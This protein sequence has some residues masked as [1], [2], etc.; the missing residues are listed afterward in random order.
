MLA[1]MIPLFTAPVLGYDSSIATYTWVPTDPNY[2]LDAIIHPGTIDLSSL[3]MGDFLGISHDQPNAIGYGDSGDIVNWDDTGVDNIG[4]PNSNG[5]ALDG[6]WVKMTR[7]KL[8]RGYWDMGFQTDIV[9]VFQSQDHDHGPYLAEGVGASVHGVNHPWGMLTAK[10]AILTDIYLDGWRI[11]N[12]REDGNGNGWCSDDIVGVY[13]FPNK[14]RYVCIVPWVGKGYNPE[15]VEVDAVAAPGSEISVNF[16]IKPG[17]CPNP[18]NRKSKGVLPV[19]I[20]GTED[21]D[22]TTIDPGTI[23]L[24]REGVDVY[25]SPLCW[26]LE[27]V[28]TPFEGELCDCHELGGDGFTD[29]TIKFKIQEVKELLSDADLDLEITLTIIGNLKEEYGGSP[30][31]GQDCVWVIK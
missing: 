6:L 28:A 26:S 27:D 10:P 22:V 11:H 9:V 30:I 14:Y 29:L 13:K 20:C 8:Y 1:A 3:V 17:S 24:T 21:F 31:S 7:E 5:D 18:I 15:S 23:Q 16:D 2:N 19:A 4:H 12:P 25:V